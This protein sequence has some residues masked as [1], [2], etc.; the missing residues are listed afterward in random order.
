MSSLEKLTLRRSEILAEMAQIDR[1]RRGGLS[2][3]YF[4]T[5]EKGRKIT[6]G[7]YYVLQCSLHGKNCCERVSADEVEDIE[8]A[9][10]G[11]EHFRQL[12][13]EFIEITEAFTLEREGSLDSKKNGKKLRRQSWMRRKHS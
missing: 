8:S 7:P 1:M 12:A 9:V 6:R 2:K 11:Y 3:Q 10:A 13:N 5:I 4:K